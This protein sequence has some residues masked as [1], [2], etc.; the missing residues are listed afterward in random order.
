M[1]KWPEG[2]TLQGGGSTSA[3]FQFVSPSRKQSLLVETRV[4][5]IF[6][7]SKHRINGFGTVGGKYPTGPVLCTKVQGQGDERWSRLFC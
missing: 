4:S 5:E 6:L 3:R 7:S 1:E 2:K